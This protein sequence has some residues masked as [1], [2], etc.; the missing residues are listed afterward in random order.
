[1]APKDRATHQS[2]DDLPRGRCHAPVRRHPVARPRTAPGACEP[3][4]LSD[5]DAVPP[6]RRRRRREGRDRQRWPPAGHD[7]V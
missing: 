1:V 2:G 3:P 7:S 5:D 4:A 6:P